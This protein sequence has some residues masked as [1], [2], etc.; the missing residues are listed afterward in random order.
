MSEWAQYLSDFMANPTDENATY[1]DK[2][3][4]YSLSAAVG[5]KDWSKGAK[6][7]DNMTWWGAACC[8]T[9]SDAGVDSD[10]AWARVYKPDGNQ[11]ILQD[12][13]TEQDVWINEY[14]TIVSG[15]SHDLTKGPLANGVWIGGNKHRIVQ[16]TTETG[17]NSEYNFVCMLAG[18]PGE[19]GH[20]VVCTDA[21]MKGKSCIVTA[22]FDKSGGVPPGMAKTVA[23][24]FAKWLHESGTDQ[25]DSITD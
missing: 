23:L 17:N 6:V 15:L 25:N 21:D 10:A 14:Q 5:G 2:F 22:E 1:S 18:R 9:D 11:K 24:D 12:D 4:N 3:K 13:D 19:K 20:M 8:A 7:P 16:K